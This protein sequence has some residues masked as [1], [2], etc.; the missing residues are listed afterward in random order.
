MGEWQ[1]QN[2]HSLIFLGVCDLC[3][4]HYDYFWLSDVTLP[5]GHPQGVADHQQHQHHEGRR[6]GVLVCADCREPVLVQGWWGQ[7]KPAMISIYFIYLTQLGWPGFVLTRAF[8]GICNTCKHSHRKVRDRTC[9]RLLV[10]Q[11]CLPLHHHAVILNLS[12]HFHIIHSDPNITC[13][14]A[15]LHFLHLIAFI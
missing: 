3:V 14:V 1:I 5:L 13:L 4:A 12:G 6:E 8:S 7:L 9:D 15:P 10:R 2:C 11:K